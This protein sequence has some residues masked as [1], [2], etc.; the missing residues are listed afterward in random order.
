M[1]QAPHLQLRVTFH[2]IQ[3]S[4]IIK[5]HLL[6]HSYLINTRHKHMHFIKVTEYPGMLRNSTRDLSV[7]TYETS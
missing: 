3:K 1:S 6:P 2:I 5:N 7:Y 4:I